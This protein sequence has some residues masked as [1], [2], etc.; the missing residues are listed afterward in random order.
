VVHVF[1]PSTWEAE[2]D[3]SLSLRPAWST[4]Q[5]PEQPG[6]HRDIVLKS[7]Q[8]SEQ[9]V[10][11]ACPLFCGNHH[12]QGNIEKNLLGPTVPL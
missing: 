6:L 7:K 1:N 8:A 3:T 11:V 5:V 10:S 4:E 12:D 2:A 9:A